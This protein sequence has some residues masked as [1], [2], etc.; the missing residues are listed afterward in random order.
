VWRQGEGTWGGGEE[1]IRDYEGGNTHAHAHTY[2]HM[3]AHTPN[4]GGRT[5][6]N[7]S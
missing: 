2:T 5:D 4:W 3:H 7:K 6:N 1:E